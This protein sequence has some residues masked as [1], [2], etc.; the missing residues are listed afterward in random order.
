MFVNHDF[1]LNRFNKYKE[2]ENFQI[3][4]FHIF[5]TDYPYL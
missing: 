1:F 3:F 5:G 4:S 2:T